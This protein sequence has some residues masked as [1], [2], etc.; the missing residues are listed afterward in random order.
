MDLYL[1]QLAPRAKPFVIW[2]AWAVEMPGAL[3][4]VRA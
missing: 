1:L 4:W 2:S 3:L